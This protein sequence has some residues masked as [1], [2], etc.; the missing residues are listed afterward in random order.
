MDHKQAEVKV[1]SASDGEFAY[2]VGDSIQPVKGGTRHDAKDMTRMGKSQELRV[3]L[4]L[5]DSSTQL[6]TDNE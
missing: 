2:D 5:E 1:D 4:L 3:R 6:H